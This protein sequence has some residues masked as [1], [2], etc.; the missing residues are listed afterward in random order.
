MLPLLGPRCDVQLLFICVSLQK[1]DSGRWFHCRD[2]EVVAI[3]AAEQ[4]KTTLCH[5]GFAGLP[6]HTHISFVHHQASS[7][8]AAWA[9]GYEPRVASFCS[10][11]TSTSSLSCKWERKAYKIS[12]FPGSLPS[13]LGQI[14]K[15]F[16]FSNRQVGSV[17]GR[18]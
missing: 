18:Q 15:F 14:M 3:R 10:K 12:A 11:T 13:L 1:P 5:L 4:L 16:N 7:F 6:L 9:L 8:L 2:G 17:I